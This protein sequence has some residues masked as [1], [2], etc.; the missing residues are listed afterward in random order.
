MPA[1]KSKPVTVVRVTSNLK[2]GVDA[3]LKPRHFLTGP[4]GSGKSAVVNAVELAL[5]GT[6][7][8]VRGRARLTQQ[9]DLLALAP[10]GENLWAEVELSN[11]QTAR[12]SVDRAGPGRS[13]NK[14]HVTPFPADKVMPLRTA[15]DFL[16]GDAKKARNFLLRATAGEVTADDVLRI[17]P[18]PLHALYAQA[19]GRVS[20]DAIADLLAARA[21][22]EANR[23]AA[24]QEHTGAQSV[25]TAS[26]EGLAPAPPDQRFAETQERLLRARA[27]AESAVA[28][29][30]QSRLPMNV[31][32]E[33]LARKIV[34]ARTTV[35]RFDAALTTPHSV[36]HAGA[37][38]RRAMADALERVFAKHEERGDGNCLICAT[39]HDPADLQQRIGNMRSALAEALQQDAEAVAHAAKLE[40]MRAKREE[41][42]AHLSRL[43]IAERMLPA[44]RASRAEL[45]AVQEQINT[46]TAARAQ[47]E[48]VRRA[49]SRITAAEQE[50]LQWQQLT[51]AIDETVRQLLDS[52]VDA[53]VASVDAQL[54][55]DFRFF[56]RLRDG[57]R[58][59]CEWGLERWQGGTQQLHSA[60]SGGEWAMVIGALAEVIGGDCPLQV[61]ALPDRDMDPATR[62]EVMRALSGTTAQ[63]LMTSCDKFHGRKPAGW[64]MLK[65]E[66]RSYDVATEEATTEDAKVAEEAPE[67]VTPVPAAPEPTLTAREQLEAA[68]KPVVKRRKA[69]PPAPDPEEI[70]A[71][72]RAAP[73]NFTARQAKLLHS[74][75]D[76]ERVLADGINSAACSVLVD[77]SIFLIP[78]APAAPSAPPPAG[79]QLD[80]L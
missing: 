21:Q 3:T 48:G 36:D 19:R 66:A 61:I 68:K 11:G 43:E 38:S 53:F 71:K 46:M 42:V 75:P 34:E 56:L 55:A 35:S 69:K 12:Y 67:E 80:L 27:G 20:A 5:T 78:A 9:L 74:G 33:E 23:K 45:D 77:G 44:L 50:A 17:L 58:E 65:L 16:I 54:P 13:R 32:A 10:T 41:W 57:Q 7:S 28:Q 60:L 14:K 18:T 70:V 62:T 4:V 52:A 79:T 76:W 24:T 49:Q 22:A 37:A 26:A 29:Y 25:L 15:E 63:V 30:T 51:A 2:G 47:A 64:H 6:V 39:A 73:H 72:L 59:V 8:D 31:E 40:Q 1:K